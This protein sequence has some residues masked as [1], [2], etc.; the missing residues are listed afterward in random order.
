MKKKSEEL[1]SIAEKPM[2]IKSHFLTNMS[3]NIRILL[4]NVVGFSQLMT[5]DGNLNEKEKQN[6]R[7]HSKRSAEL[8]QLVNNV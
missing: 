5:E 3:Y 8:I 6:A 4:N 7:H 2:E 1:T